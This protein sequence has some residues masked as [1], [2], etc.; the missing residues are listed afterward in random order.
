MQ[1]IYEPDPSKRDF[2][3]AVLV[4]ATIA[5]RW[6]LESV[7]AGEPELEPGITLRPKNE[8]RTVVRGR[9]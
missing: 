9:H 7:D 5:R 2:T 4:L 3:P 1:A 8:I 6:R